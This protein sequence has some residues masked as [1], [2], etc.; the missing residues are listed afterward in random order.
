MKQYL[1]IGIGLAFMTILALSCEK[2][3]PAENIQ[4]NYSGY[5]SGVYDGNDTIIANYPVYATATTKNKI[6]I[7]GGMFPSFEVLVS[8][9]GINVIPVSTDNEV[10]DFLYQGDLKELSF[11]YYKNGDSTDFVG[12]KP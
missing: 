6:K 5:L 9:N 1:K 10:Y 12:T 8:Q 4:G 3:Q 7:E 11:K 2:E